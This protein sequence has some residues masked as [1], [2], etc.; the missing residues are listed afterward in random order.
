MRT[1]VGSIGHGATPERN[2]EPRVWCPSAPA[3]IN[4]EKRYLPVLLKSPHLLQG[5]RLNLRS[6]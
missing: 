4:S 2:E 1:N 5:G 3:F 6:A